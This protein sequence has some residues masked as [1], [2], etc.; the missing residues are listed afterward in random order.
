MAAFAA[1]PLQIPEKKRWTIVDWET[2]SH[3]ETNTQRLLSETMTCGKLRTENTYIRHQE[4]GCD[5]QRMAS[6]GYAICDMFYFSFWFKPRRHEIRYN[7]SFLDPVPSSESSII[8]VERFLLELGF[9]LGGPLSWI[10]FDYST[11]LFRR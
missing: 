11:V 10:G 1:P 3:Y 8:S 7:T 5:E 4:N 2:C 9:Y 6:A